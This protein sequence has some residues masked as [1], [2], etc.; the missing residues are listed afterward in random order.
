MKRNGE[1]TQFFHPSAG[2]FTP[3]SERTDIKRTL[4]TA[5]VPIF[6][7]APATKPSTKKT[8]VEALQR[9]IESGEFLDLAQGS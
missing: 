1:C 4:V 2:S 6:Y 5:A 7:Q 9:C 8:I 3:R